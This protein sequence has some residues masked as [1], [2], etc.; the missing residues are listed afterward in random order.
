MQV[1]ALPRGPIW[2]ANRSS[3]PGLGAN[4]CALL[5]E[6]V[7]QAHGIPP[8]FNAGNEEEETEVT[9]ADQNPA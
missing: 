2:N 7:V 5:S 1:Q 3:V 6:G 9:E 4:E 8:F